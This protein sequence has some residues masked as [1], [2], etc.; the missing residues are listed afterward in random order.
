MRGFFKN[1]NRSHDQ[2]KGIETI[3]YNHLNLP[4]E[5][6]FV[7]DNRKINYLY[8]ATGQKLRKI[9]NEG[10]ALSITD[11]LGGYQHNNAP[12]SGAGGLLLF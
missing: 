3:K 2:N 4:T 12:P 11:Y 5:I 1:G 6:I 7:G 10:I 8:T 9:V